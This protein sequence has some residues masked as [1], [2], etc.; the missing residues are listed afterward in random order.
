[1]AAPAPAVLIIQTNPSGLQFSIDGG[2]VQAAPQ[3]LSLAAGSTHSIAVAA[4]QPG[5]AGA[6]YV[7]TGW[8]DGGPAS[9]SF[10]VNG[11][12]TLTASFKTQYQLT[13]LAVPLI[14]GAVTPATG[15]FYDSGVVVPVSAAANTGYSFTNWT[16]NV[17]AA[18]AAST[19]VTMG[20]PQSVSANFT[21][22]APAINAG[23]IVPLYSSVSAI[24][25]GSWISIYGSNLARGT[26]VWNGDFPTSLGGVSVKINNKPG[27]LWLVSPGQ[28]NLQSP[29]DTAMGTVNVTVTTPNGTVSSTVTLAPF[30]PSFSLLSAR[31]AA[32]VILT[33]DGSGA[34]GN[35]VYDLL[36]PSGQF[37]FKTRPV[38]AG[39]IL[40]LY[41][42]GFGPTTPPV[43]AGMPFIGA[44]PTS[45]TVV[46]TIGG[47]PA[48]VLF[49]G[50]TS[51]GLYQFN[52]AVPN[53][54]SGD[55]LIRAT[56]GGAQ[57]PDA[58]YVTVQ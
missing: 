16:G 44:A 5:A 52:I 32:G 46:V 11:P 53:V 1:M 37:G 42:V 17:A 26:M 13:L 57:T 4:V 8:S 7:F 58:V 12:V 29:D 50:I 47:V 55:R 30:G 34:Y 38:K 18:A 45:N 15:A 40:E 20:A 22:T 51:S 49:A 31:Y 19:T 39:E 54:G 21:A 56:T 24:Q 25:P 36:G 35:G 41:G 10:T 33:P 27:Y 2:S 28:I 9:H 48:N 14:G 6:Q 3:T 43:P 23:G